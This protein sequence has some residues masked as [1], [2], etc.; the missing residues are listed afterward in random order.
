M[1]MVDEQGKSVSRRVYWDADV[2]AEELERIYKHCWVFVAHES[3]IPANGDYVTRRMGE[4]AVIVTR[5]ETGQP[6]VFLNTCRHRGVALCSADMGNTSHF[7]CSYHGW[8]YSNRG[9]L[10]G[11]PEMRDVY[12]ENFDKGDFNLIEPAGVDVFCGLIFACWDP[13]A[14]KLE[15]YLKDIGWYLDAMLTKAGDMQVVGP[16]T[17][18]I[19]HTNWKIGAENY[20]GDGYHLN[21]THKTPIELG[22]F[23][24]E[25]EMAALGEPDTKATLAHC[26]DGGNGHTVRI[27]QLPIKFEQPTFLGYPPQLWPTFVE[28][29]DEHQ[30]DVMSG[31]AV[32][33][34]NVFPNLSFI[35]TVI[36]SS[37]DTTPP[38]A[39]VHLR[40]WQPLGPD[41]TE[42]VLWCLVPK[43]GYDEQDT[44]NT[45]RAF[46]RSLGV[47]GIFETDDFQNWTSMAEVSGG[48]VAVDH[49]YNYQGGSHLP[50]ESDKP[51]AGHVYAADHTEVNQRAMYLR[52]DELMSSNGNGN[53]SA[54]GRRSSGR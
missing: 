36:V 28:N 21:T 3:E 13:E 44:I 43:E 4:D 30:R 42:L 23:G 48:P 34:G 19:V 32:M 6:R 37:G 52:W 27:Q 20:A 7:R 49:T 11:V 10:R 51:W 26:V 8:T 18:M 9:D 15:E 45:Q 29:L 41:K 39:Y 38:T 35:D 22:V 1:A 16:P 5:D 24:T 2:Y 17:R 53:G 12:G 25:H 33:H 50:A 46:V 47:G 14:P 31:L 40:Q 54:N